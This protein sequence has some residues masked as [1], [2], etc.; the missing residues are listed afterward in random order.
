MKKIELTQGQVA[1]VDKEDYDKLQ[2]F[3]WRCCFAKSDLKYAH[4]QINKKSILLHRFILDLKKGEM[5]DHINGDGLD[6]RRSNLRKCSFSQNMFNMRIFKNNKCGYK[7][8]YYRNDKPRSKPWKATINA[9]KK[10]YNLGYF[11]TSIE[12]AR[13]YDVAALKHHGEFAR[14]NL[15]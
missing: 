6:N 12:A 9:N 8:V 13:A 3:K 1:I 4:A 15:K 2:Q 5:A 7:G 11:E 10:R 14:F